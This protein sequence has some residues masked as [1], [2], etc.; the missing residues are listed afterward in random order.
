M[1]SVKWFS[2]THVVIALIFGFI[3][4]SS[5]ANSGRTIDG[6]VP[7]DRV[8]NINCR[9]LRGCMPPKTCIPYLLD[10]SGDKHCCCY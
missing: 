1:A 2:L 8:P 6:L 4:I 5:L 10:P 7:Q 9:I 3:L